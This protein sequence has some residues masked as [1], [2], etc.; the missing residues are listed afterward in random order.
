MRKNTDALRTDTFDV[1][2]LDPE[3]CIMAYKR[4]NDAGSVAVVVA[5][6]KDEFGGKV[7]IPNWPGDGKWHEYINNYDVEASGGTLTDSLAESEV[8]IYLKAG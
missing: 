4:W 8:K 2:H 5:H 1:V 7:T 3:R 6:L